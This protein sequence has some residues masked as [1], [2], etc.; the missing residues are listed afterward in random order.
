MHVNRTVPA[1]LH[2]ADPEGLARIVF[3]LIGTS[4]PGNVGAAA[5]AMMTMGLS[6]LRL[7]A[8]RLADV[9]Q[10]S[11]AQ[12][13]ASGATDVLNGA[14]V[15]ATL[16][17]ALADVCLAVAVSAEPREFGPPPQVPQAAAAEACSV[18]RTQPDDRV[19]FVFGPERTG[20]SIAAVQAC[21]RLV[22]I[23]ASPRYASLN[24]AQAVMILAY[25]LRCAAFSSATG[26]GEGGASVPV[27]PAERLADHHAVA[28]VLAHLERA[29]LTIGFLD[30][31]H[32]KKLMP[33]LR[34]LVLRS[35]LRV[36]EVDL[37][38]GIFKLTE[39][40]ARPKTGPASR[41]D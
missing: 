36:E 1:S 4:H 28:G 31:A 26:H 38:R 37:L 7:V 15:F 41:G 29:L 17:E 14:R 39:R 19:A 24:L 21:G 10:H 20:L 23:P 8:P 11:E 35:Q 12:A 3:V 5:R 34:R 22:S 25:A 2:E 33:R 18:L 30:P 16:D 9:C 6:D 32:P 13:R 27:P 40:S